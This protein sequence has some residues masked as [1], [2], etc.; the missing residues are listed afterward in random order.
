MGQYVQFADLLAS[1]TRSKGFRPMTNTRRFAIAWVLILSFAATWRQADDPP[2]GE[3]QTS[4]TPGEFPKNDRVGN[5]A[6]PRP[7]PKE[8][9]LYSARGDA[10]FFAG[11]FFWRSQGLRE[12]GRTQ[13]R[14]IAPSHWRRGIAYFYA[15]QYKKA[16]NQFEIYHIPS[17]MWTAKTESGGSSRR[18]R[19]TA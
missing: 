14:E 12:D 4:G 1:R 10:R 17:T 15:K 2:L 3:V 6:D 18:P 8:V 11:R 13:R 16:A 9:S 7:H 19:P 5:Q